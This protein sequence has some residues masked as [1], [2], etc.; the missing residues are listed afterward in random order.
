MADEFDENI[1]ETQSILLDY[2]KSRE[3]IKDQHVVVVTAS[4]LSILFLFGMLNFALTPLA[5]KS[6]DEV[7]THMLSAFIIT[8]VIFSGLMFTL[9]LIFGIDLIRFL[10]NGKK[11]NSILQKA[12]SRLI[13]KSYL[14]NFELVSA[15]GTTQIDRLF[16]H[17]SLVFP[18]VKLI[19]QKLVKKK[20][21]SV[22]Q[23]R[24]K[25]FRPIVFFPKGFDLDI[26]TITGSYYVKIFD[27]KVTFEDI[28][29][30]LQLAQNPTNKIKR[31]FFN[32]KLNRLIILSKSY[33]DFFETPEFIEEMT[34]LKRS[35]HLDLILEEN[36]NGYSTIWID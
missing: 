18:E 17:L 16:N 27:K 9:L 12:Q 11:Q 4:L 28:K 34:K 24:G 32:I 21:T 3:T 36:D 22:E 26:Y 25:V 10:K 20:I 1:D 2:L 5:D 13:H 14:L 6:L 29:E 8:F 19:K 31:G 35:F 15:E 30:I 7:G 23:R 33:D